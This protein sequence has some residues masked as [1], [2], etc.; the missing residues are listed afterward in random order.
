M[1]GA[2]GVDDIAQVEEV[3]E[4]WLTWIRGLEIRRIYYYWKCMCLTG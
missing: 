3:K 1:R 2:I 4:E